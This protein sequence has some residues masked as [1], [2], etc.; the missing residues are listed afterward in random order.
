M[1]YATHPVKMWNIQFWPGAI[2]KIAA[3][4]CEEKGS[5]LK[6][7]R[8]DQTHFG[9]EMTLYAGNHI[10]IHHHLWKK[11]DRQKDRTE[12]QTHC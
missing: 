6:A 3:I 5:G 1:L 2:V 9:T 8:D 4:N 10:R 11:P 7:S 12:G